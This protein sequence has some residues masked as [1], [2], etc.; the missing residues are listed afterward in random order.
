MEVVVSGRHCLPY[1]SND[2][3]IRRTIV[4]AVYLAKGNLLYASHI[5]GIHRKTLY[6][7]LRTFYLWPEVNRIRADVMKRHASPD[8]DS[9]LGRARLTLRG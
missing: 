6:V 3:E 9:L 2:S 7:A 1:C 8:P 5:L 4:D